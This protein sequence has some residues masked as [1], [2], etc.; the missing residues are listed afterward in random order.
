MAEV[1]VAWAVQ[2]VT[3]IELAAGSFA[4]AATTA[5]AVV[6]VASTYGTAQIRRGE[7]EIAK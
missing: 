7:I 4:L 1:V 6:A 2:A 3:G 5:V